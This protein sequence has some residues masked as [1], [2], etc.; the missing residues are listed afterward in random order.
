MLSQAGLGVR[1]RSLI[2]NGTK[3]TGSQIFWELLPWKN[4]PI[5]RILV[6]VGRDV[7]ITSKESL[8]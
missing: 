8:R 3:T 4:L 5:M 2:S 1:N 7:F 6:P